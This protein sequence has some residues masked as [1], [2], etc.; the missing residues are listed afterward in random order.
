MLLVGPVVVLDT[1]GSLLR[2]LEPL[3][4]AVSSILVL[5]HCRR[6]GHLLPVKVLLVSAIIV[7]D[8]N[9]RFGLFLLAARLSDLTLAEAMAD[10]VAALS[11]SESLD[12]TFV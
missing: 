12:A 10:S 11:A 2:L 3:V 4:L 7:L 8:D 1:H 9:G 6:L 5:Y